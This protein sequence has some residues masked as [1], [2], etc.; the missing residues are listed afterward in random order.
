[1]LL[2]EGACGGVHGDDREAHLQDPAVHDGTHGVR[3]TD[4]PLVVYSLGRS[5]PGRPSAQRPRHSAHPP[6]P[7][8]TPGLALEGPPCG[9]AG[10]GVPAPG[11][12]ELRTS[13]HLV[14]R[15]SAKQIH[16]GPPLLWPNVRWICGGAPSTNTPGGGEG[17]GAGRVQSQGEGKSLGGLGNGLRVLSI[18]FL[19]LFSSVSMHMHCFCNNCKKPT[20]SVNK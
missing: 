20:T 19:G 6:Q 5:N 2:G 13:R 9:E 12:G 17:R 15:T 18:V 7:G 8:Q 1:M 16:V 3:Q 4:G 11:L 10:A 14:R